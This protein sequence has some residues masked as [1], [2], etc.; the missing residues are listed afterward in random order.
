MRIIRNALYLF[1]EFSVVCVQ[2]HSV[3]NSSGY[4][5]D[6]HYGQD[7]PYSCSLSEVHL[8]L[9]ESMKNNCRVK[10]HVTTDQLKSF[11]TI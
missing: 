10:Q 6:V 3:R 5:V 8:I 1:I 7:G 4:I 11:E 9:P 2:F